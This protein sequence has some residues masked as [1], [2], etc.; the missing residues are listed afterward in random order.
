MQIGQAIGMVTLNDALIDLVAKKLVAP[1]EAY[2][3]AVDKTGFEAL[4]KRARHRHEVHQQP[5]RKTPNSRNRTCDRRLALGQ[6]RRLL[7][8]DLLARQNRN[9]APSCTCLGYPMLGM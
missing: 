5:R 8:E 7:I 4:L 6:R 9:R 1:E 2:M 3:K